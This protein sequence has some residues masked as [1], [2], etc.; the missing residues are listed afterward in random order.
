MTSA[1][2]FDIQSAYLIPRKQK[3]KQIGKQCNKLALVLMT[4][5]SPKKWYSE[6]DCNCQDKNGQKHYDDQHQV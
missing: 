3:D 1:S 6:Y 4:L 2:S 5:V